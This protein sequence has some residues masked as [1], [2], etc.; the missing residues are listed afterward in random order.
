MLLKL[1][2]LSVL[3]CICLKTTN[4]QETKCKILEPITDFDQH[5]RAYCYNAYEEDLESF[6]ETHML[7]HELKLA[8]TNIQYIHEYMFLRY[9]NLTN[10]T[11]I[12]SAIEEIEQSSLSQLENLEVLEISLS[13][14]QKLDDFAFGNLTNL[15]QLILNDNFIG[16]ID[17]YTF[18]N[19]T[20][21]R[22]LQ[23][24]NNELEVI[25][26]DTF[27]GLTNVEV[28]DLSGNPIEYIEELSFDSCFSLKKLIL[29]KSSQFFLSDLFLSYDFEVVFV[30]SEFKSQQRLKMVISQEIEELMKFKPTSLTSPILAL[31]MIISLICGIIFLLV[32]TVFISFILK[33]YKYINENCS[34]LTGPVAGG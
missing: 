31:S 21:L 27:V 20:N 17:P 9:S 3:L 22:E 8:R 7:I 18:S 29:E 30:T 12:D 23:L 32:A 33:R 26:Q 16:E 11:I 10:L 25:Y 14:L 1:S 15:Y 6:Y 4:S 5:I 19:L 2:L 28:I 13:E 24:R 34:Q